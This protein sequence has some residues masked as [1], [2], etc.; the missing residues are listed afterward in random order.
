[1]MTITMII[2]VTMMNLHFD[3][4]KLNLLNIYYNYNPSSALG[5]L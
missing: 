4:I 3:G 5:D 2:V 1:M